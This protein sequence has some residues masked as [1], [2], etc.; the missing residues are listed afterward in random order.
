MIQTILH[1][2]DTHGLHLQLGTLPDADVLVHSGNFTTDGTEQEVFDFIE[3]F[4]SQPHPHKIFIA[5]NHDTCLYQN[6]LEGL[7]D[8]AYYLC[9]SSIEIDYVK[10]YGLPLFTQDVATKLYEKHIR[11]IPYDTNILITH[12][13]PLGIRDYSE[14]TH[15][16]NL[17]LLQ[18]VTAIKPQYHI[19]G[20]IHHAYGIEHIAHTFYINSALS[21]NTHKMTQKP[22]LLFLPK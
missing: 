4:I 21:D 3:W 17:E 5:G 7:P 11:T 8:N 2:S 18:Q 6:H 16:R 10:F 9:N 20:H 22:Q 12:Q 1:L 14:N 15:W 13:P 19:F